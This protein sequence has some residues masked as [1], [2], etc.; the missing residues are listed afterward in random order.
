MSDWCGVHGSRRRIYQSPVSE[1]CRR[2]VPQKSAALGLLLWAK[3]QSDALAS[4]V[5]LAPATVTKLSVR[6]V[7]SRLRVGDGESLSDSR[8]WRADSQTSAH[9]CCVRTRVQTPSIVL[10][11]PSTHIHVAATLSSAFAVYTT[12]SHYSCVC[13]SDGWLL[14]RLDAIRHCN[15]STECISTPC[16]TMAADLPCHACEGKS[17][18]LQASVPVGRRRTV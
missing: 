7:Q 1:E 16:K 5:Q 11:F 9:R 18:L 4:S 3:A 8:D 14:R 15:T 17:Q 12:A 10:P 2:R 6:P 13:G